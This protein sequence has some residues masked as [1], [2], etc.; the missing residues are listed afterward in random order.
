MPGP[1]FTAYSEV[2]GKPGLYRFERGTK[3]PVELY[4]P[5]AE[6]YKQ[7]IDRFNAQTALQAAR[8]SVEAAAAPERLPARAPAQQADEEARRRAPLG[9]ARRVS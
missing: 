3:P 1:M 7:Q 8:P 9:A 2:P 6:Q 4:G 5:P